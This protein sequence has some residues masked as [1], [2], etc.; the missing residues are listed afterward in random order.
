M[1]PALTGIGS[2]RSATVLS[3]IVC[4]SAAASPNGTERVRN[5]FDAQRAARS[6]ES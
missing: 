2:S 6:D 5:Y 4:A 1:M 3:S